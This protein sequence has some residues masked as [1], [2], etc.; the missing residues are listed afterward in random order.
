MDLKFMT[1]H[2]DTPFSSSIEDLVESWKKS[3]FPSTKFTSYFPT[4]VELFNHLRGTDCTFIETGVLDG[5]SLF[6]WRSWLGNKAKIIGIDLN[7]DALKWKD[8]GFDI[9]IGDQGDPQF[10]QST[11]AKI[12]DFDALLDDGGHQSFQQIVT[13]RE[14]MRNSNKRCIVAIEDTTTSFMKDFSMHGKF[15]FLEYSKDA[16]DILTGR[17]VDIYPGRFPSTV[18]TQS[19]EH[20]R[21]TYSIRFYNGIV[22]F[23]IDPGLSFK[24]E[25]VRNMP[26]GTASD[27]RYEGIDSALIDWPNPFKKQSVIVKGGMNRQPWLWK[28]NSAYRKLIS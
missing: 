8:H 2:T 14:S 7:P 1:V 6:M 20:F 3:P 22:A 16:T 26:S 27:F 19:I 17:S 10:W 28:L 13:A 25:L 18:N 23:M 21:N 12:G 24:P 5:G 9:Y 15:S 11:L 4:Y